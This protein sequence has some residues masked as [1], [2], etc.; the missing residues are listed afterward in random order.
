MSKDPLGIMA[1]K[2]EPIEYELSEKLTF[3]LRKQI[4][5]CLFLCW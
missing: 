2:E 4:V 3:F 1:K 5:G